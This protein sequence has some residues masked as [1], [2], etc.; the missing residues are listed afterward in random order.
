MENTE[1]ETILTVRQLNY[2]GEEGALPLHSLKTENRILSKEERR[3]ALR[4]IASNYE[5]SLQSP[6]KQIAQ[7]LQEQEN[8][9]ALLKNQFLKLF[10]PHTFSQSEKEYI[11]ETLLKKPD[12]INTQD[13]RQVFEFCASTLTP[14]IEVWFQSLLDFSELKQF[15]DIQTDT[16]LQHFIFRAHCLSGDVPMVATLMDNFSLQENSAQFYDTLAA[17]IK[18]GKI[19]VIEYLF[20]YGQLD[21][22]HKT[23]QKAALD[24]SLN[25]EAVEKNIMVQKLLF[26][27]FLKPDLNSKSKKTKIQKI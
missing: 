1:C 14:H 2:V 15:Y 26:S 3:A 19:S 16:E 13:L 8:N 6:E 21:P 20:R 18:F 4:S 5:A 24:L 17:T 10:I 9:L 23:L 27:D 25:P 7:T 11:V 12:Y 22:N